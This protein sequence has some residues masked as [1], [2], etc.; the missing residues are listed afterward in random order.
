[1]VE[2]LPVATKIALLHQTDLY[3]TQF[4]QI[5]TNVFTLNST[6]PSHTHRL[7]I[8]ESNNSHKH[9]AAAHA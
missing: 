8:K 6:P 5:R 4:M 9:N 2:N 1:M 7:A 3:T